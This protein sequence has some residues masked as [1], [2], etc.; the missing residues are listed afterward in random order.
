M[1]KLPDRIPETM[2]DSISIS[3]PSGRVSKR[4]R[5]KT[6]ERLRKSLFGDGLEKPQI[7]QPS[8][9]EILRRQALEF[10]GLAARG[11]K[12]RAYSKKADEIESKIKKLEDTL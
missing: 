9:L 2:G 1:K 4:S 8:K 11:M 6:L 5:D 3:S 12:P 10:R 7:S